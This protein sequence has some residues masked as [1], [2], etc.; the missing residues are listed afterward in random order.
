M[1]EQ[2]H[3]YGNNFERKSYKYTPNRIKVGE[4]GMNQKPLSIGGAADQHMICRSELHAGTIPNS[5]K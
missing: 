5:L 2:F 3:E 1:R 4:G